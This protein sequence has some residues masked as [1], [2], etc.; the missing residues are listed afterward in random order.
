MTEKYE[1][2]KKQKMIQLIRECNTSGMG[3]KEWCRENGLS[4]STL[5]KWQK[6]LREE[7]AEELTGKPQIVQ[8][9]LP[10]EPLSPTPQKETL[11]DQGNETVT[12]RIGDET[13]TLPVGM[14]TADIIEIIRGI[15]L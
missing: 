6:R 12:I 1:E 4:Y 15:R 3:K 9:R 10:Q 8:L 5:M 7:I 2:L 11:S 14:K 13:I